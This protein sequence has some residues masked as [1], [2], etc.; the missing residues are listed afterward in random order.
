ME[1]GRREGRGERRLGSSIVGRCLWLLVGEG[2][3]SLWS[4]S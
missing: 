1:K 2:G 4:V 3:V